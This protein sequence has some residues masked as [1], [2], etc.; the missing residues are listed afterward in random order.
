MEKLTGKSVVFTGGTSGLGLEA[1]KELLG[2]GADVVLLYR[3]KSKLKQLFETA[4]NAGLPGKIYPFEADMTDLKSLVNACKGINENF[5]K[6]DL[7]VNN[8]AIWSFKFERSANGIETTFQVNVLA[9]VLM[10]HLLKDKMKGGLVIN[11]ASGLHQGTIHFGD[12]EYSQ[13]FSGFRAYRQSKL[14]IIMLTRL[15]A[16]TFAKE[17]IRFCSQHPGLVNTE[18]VR[19]GSWF[20]K[21]F[22]QLFGMSPKKGAQTLLHLCNVLP[23]E[24]EN[25]AYY[26]KSR[27]AKTTTPQSYDMEMAAILYKRCMVYLEPFLNVSDGSK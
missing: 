25:G 18:L 7:L 10:I 23:Q 24:I 5:K 19:Q 22:F 16:N 21:L 13:S 20:A 4:K 17:D 9:P 3:D 12:I 6:I 8:A 26:L 15:Y 1:V 14:A 2:A 11:T 27:P